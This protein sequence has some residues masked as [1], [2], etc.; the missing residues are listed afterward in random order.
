MSP[1]V[2]ILTTLSRIVPWSSI[3]YMNVYVSCVLGVDRVESNLIAQHSSLIATGCLILQWHCI[4]SKKIGNKFFFTC[5]FIHEK[6][7]IIFKVMI[8]FLTNS[9]NC[10]ALWTTRSEDKIFNP[11]GRPYGQKLIF[12]KNLLCYCY[13]SIHEP[14]YKYCAYLLAV[15][16]CCLINS[17]KNLWVMS[18]VFES[19]NASMVSIVSFSSPFLDDSNFWGCKNMQFKYLMEYAHSSK[20]Y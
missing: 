7:K 20:K 18:F 8:D 9:T 15:S 10:L 19:T 16:F 13:V 6:L 2:Y 3:H 12:W 17:S 5:S 14:V 4:D 11:K 1:K